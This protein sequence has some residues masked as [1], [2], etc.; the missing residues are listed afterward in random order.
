MNIEEVRKNAP[1]GATHYINHYGIK[2]YKLDNLERVYIYENN[3]L[4][5]WRCLYLHVSETVL[6]PL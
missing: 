1:C 2:Y 3:G 6:K 5:G 4:D